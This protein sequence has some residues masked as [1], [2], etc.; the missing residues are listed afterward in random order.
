MGIYKGPEGQPHQTQKLNTDKTSRADSQQIHPP[1]SEAL[2]LEQA[3]QIFSI[4]KEKKSMQNLPY[5]E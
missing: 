4:A 2:F 3:K 1:K 5:A